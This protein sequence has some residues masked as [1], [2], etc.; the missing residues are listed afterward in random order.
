[1]KYDKKKGLVILLIVLLIIFINLVSAPDGFPTDQILGQLT[2]LPSQLAIGAT[3]NP[4][5]AKQVGADLKVSIVNDHLEPGALKRRQQGATHPVAIG[6]S[7][8]DKDV[9][10]WLV[11]G[12]L[13][14]Q[15]RDARP[16]ARL[17][18]MVYVIG[19]HTASRTRDIKQCVLLMVLVLGVRGALD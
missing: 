18:L 1:M 14:A 16:C 6:V 3:W 4:E 8:R 9:V 5:F 17:G 19:C 13:C 12:F 7:I 2:P 11:H 10:L 15:A